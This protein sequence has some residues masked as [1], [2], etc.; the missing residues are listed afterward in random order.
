MYLEAVDVIYFEKYH[1]QWY[2]NYQIPCKF[3]NIVT[4]LL[5][6]RILS[7]AELD[8]KYIEFHLVI[9]QA[10]IAWSYFVK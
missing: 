3:K 6:K 1:T 8:W 7:F 9:T 10:C 4:M 5:G 2:F